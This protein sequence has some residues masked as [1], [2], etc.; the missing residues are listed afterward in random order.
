MS[1]IKFEWKPGETFSIHPILRKQLAE[2]IYKLVSDNKLMSEDFVIK[3]YQ[4]SHHISPK[5]INAIIA[6]LKENPD[7]VSQ[8]KNTYIQYSN[9]TSSVLAEISGPGNIL[10]ILDKVR[11]MESIEQTI[12]RNSLSDLAISENLDYEDNSIA[13]VN[14]KTSDDSIQD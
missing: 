5:I 9:Q 10:P 2:K 7:Y 14:L 12:S 6:V 11:E 4:G 8:N 1:K 3:A 13:P